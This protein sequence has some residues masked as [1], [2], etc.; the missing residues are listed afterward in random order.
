[1]KFSVIATFFC[2]ADLA[3]LADYE[4]L[5]ADTVF[6]EGLADLA[7]LADRSVFFL[8]DTDLAAKLDLAFYHK[9]PLNL[10]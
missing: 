8:A 2:L 1:M 7:D 3:V 9:K 6:W 5:L 10:R 4:F